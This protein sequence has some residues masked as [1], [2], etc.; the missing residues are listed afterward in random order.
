MRKSRRWVSAAAA[1]LLAATLAPLAPAAT[2]TADN[3]V[4]DPI[5]DPIRDNPTPT[6]L[7][8]VLEEYAQLPAST[9]NGPW[10]DVRLGDRHNRINYIGELPDG[11][12]RMYVPDLNGSLYFL[13]H[14]E[15]KVYLDV[16]AQFPNFMSWRGLGTGF[17]FV[18]FHPEF[19]SNGKFYTVHSETPTAPGEST[20]APATDVQL[21]SERGHR[22]DRRRPRG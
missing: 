21:G 2:S 5:T 1:T 6:S 11:S 20:Y 14:G 18:A 8:L 7:G 15:S 4:D 3:Q 19:E 13:D 16:K 10:T 9:P 17:G 12:G 22:M